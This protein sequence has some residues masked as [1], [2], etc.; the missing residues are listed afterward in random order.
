[1]IDCCQDLTTDEFLEIKSG[2]YQNRLYMEQDLWA[3]E[4]LTETSH[5]FND[6]GLILRPK[7]SSYGYVGGDV[8]SWTHPITGKTYTF[9]KEIDTYGGG[10]LYVRPVSNSNR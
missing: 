10:V 3:G 5:I 1:M 6:H 4:V 2:F 8:P 9:Y 7:E